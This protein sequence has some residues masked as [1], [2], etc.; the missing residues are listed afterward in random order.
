MSINTREITVDQ[1]LQSKQTDVKSSWPSYHLLRANTSCSVAASH[2]LIV[3]SKL[4]VA[5]R[6]QS[7]EKA[8][9]QTAYKC[10]LRVSISCPVAASHS[11]IVRS[12][13]PVAS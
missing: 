11:L 3:Q 8:T 10:P 2:S 12:P 1:T 7:G 6:F 4:P 13:L 9:D 5:S